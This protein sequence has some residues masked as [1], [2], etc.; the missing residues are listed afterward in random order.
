MERGSAIRK[1]GRVSLSQSRPV[2]IMLIRF[3]R[4]TGAM[5][6]SGNFWLSCDI[7]EV[8]TM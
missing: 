5:E 4:H 7:K 2:E 3:T 8:C 1:A 6:R